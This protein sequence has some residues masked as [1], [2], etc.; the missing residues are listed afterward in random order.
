MRILGIDYGVKR[1]GLAVSDPT[2]MLA[3]PLE[4]LKRR[5]GKRPPVHRVAEIAREHEAAAVVVGLPLGLDGEENDWCR[6]VRSFGEALGTRIGVPVH[7]VDER[8]TS[9]MAEKAIRQSGLGLLKRREKERVDRAA[10]V[11]ILQRW[12]DRTRGEPTA[13]PEDV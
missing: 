3:G 12:L 11:L 2:G 13:P 10:A 4:T 1:V 7:F 8:M 6:E 9:V 5:P